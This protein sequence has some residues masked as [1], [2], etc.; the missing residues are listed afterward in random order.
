MNDS[1]L[2]PSSKPTKPSR[3]KR[4]VTKVRLKKGF[5]LHDWAHLLK[6]SKDPSQRRGA[7]IRRDI[8]KEEIRLHNDEHDG[9]VILRGVVYNLTPYLHYHPGGVDILKP[10]LGR[11]A[12]ALF[13][14]YHRW[15]NIQALIGPLIVGYLATAKKKNDHASS[16]SSI[17]KAK[18][19]GD[20]EFAVPAPRPPSTAARVAALPS[21]KKSHE[22][23]EEEDLNP[24]ERS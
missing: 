12:T 11:D 5:G 23:E 3:T 10:C 19:N 16:S 18:G 21:P 6:I 8:S 2:P 24:W 22:E 20:F 9:W 1:T 4:V 7:P 15:V 13:D 17:A 14:K